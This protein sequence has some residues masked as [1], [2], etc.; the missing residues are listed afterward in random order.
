MNTFDASM[1]ILGLYNFKIAY[2][3]LGIPFE[4]E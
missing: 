2:L 4:A 1:F 3:A